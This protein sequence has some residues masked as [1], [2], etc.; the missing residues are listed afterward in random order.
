MIATPVVETSAGLDSASE[1]VVLVFEQ[2][3]GCMISDFRF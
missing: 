3:A 2:D 1:L